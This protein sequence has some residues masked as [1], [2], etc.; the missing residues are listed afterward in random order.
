[1]DN[2]RIAWRGMSHS[3]AL[4]DYVRQ[5]ALKQE[6]YLKDLHSCHITVGRDSHHSHKGP[7]SYEVHVE[8][9]GPGTD[10]NVARHG[11]D[12]ERAVH[13]AFDALGKQL[14]RHHDKRREEPRRHVERD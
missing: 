9:R 2:V 5:H 14:R 6:R 12:P 7:G 8:V 4:E 1:M 13:D 10:L 11:E 3:E